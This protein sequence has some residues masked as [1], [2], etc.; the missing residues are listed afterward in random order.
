MAI[1]ELEILGS[2]AKIEETAPNYSLHSGLL[3]DGKLL[4]DVGEK[5]YLE[6]DPE[7]IFITHL[8]PD[9][10]FFV[11][12]E[13]NSLDCTIYAPEKSEEVDVTVLNESIELDGYR[14]TPVPTHHSKL[15]DSQAYIIAKGG[16]RLLYTGD[17]IWINKEYHD[18]LQDLDLVITDGSYIRKG[19]LVRR[20]EE[21]GQIYGH[22]GIPDLVNLFKKFTDRIIFTHFGGW[23]YDDIEESRKKIEDPS[24][25]GVSVEAAHD[26]MK[27]KI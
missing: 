5:E 11:T 20:D 24:E 8:H 17:L 27:L 13:L 9:H 2:R 6:K 15:V 18:K 19:G 22:N 16:K 23:F 4:F 25:E 26:G 10:A 21:T 1:L 14:I 7:Y 3:V 12:N